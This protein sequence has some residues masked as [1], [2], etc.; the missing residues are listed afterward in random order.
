MDDRITYNRAKTWQIALFTLNNTATNTALF[1]MGYYAYFSQNILGLAAVM[2]GGIA[3]AMRVFDG[4]TDPAIGFMLDKTNTKFGR[5]RP[6]MLA[7][8]LIMCVCIAGI[9]HA[10]TGM[11]TAG[12]YIYTTVL[13]V[14][15][16]IGYTCQTAVTK[17]AQAVITN[18]PKQRPLF[19][20]FDA[21]FTRVSGAMI[22]VLITTILAEKYAIGDYAGAGMLNP[23]MWRVASV[24]LCTAILAMTIL[25]MAGISAKDKPEYYVK[26]GAAKVQLKDY[27]DIIVHNR[28]IQMLIIAAATDKLGSLLQNGLLVYLFA[29]L[30]LNSKMQGIYTI[31]CLVPVMAAA[32]IG[33]GVAR[34]VGLKK[35]FVAGT[36]GSLIMLLILFVYKPDP[37][38]PWIWIVLYIIQN[39]I[40]VFANGSVIPMLADCTDYETYRSGKFVPGMIGTMF[41]FIDKLLSSLSSLIVGIALT[42]AGVGNTTIVPNQPVGGR[43]NTVILL[44]F[45]G[46]PILGYI[47]SL[48][49]M[50]FYELDAAKM[51]K[52]QAGL[53]R[54]KI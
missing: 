42:V 25:A 30:L 27:V 20:G 10:P 2:V 37:N 16:I 13:Y 8:S 35:N 38:V 19:S 47:A 53:E 3:T 28:P 29:N 34:K 51:E 46:I 33:V 40:V 36:T 6:F 52:I 44:C 5:F 15:Y 14:L 49:S 23:E 41:S 9:F 24:I 48:I 4:I 31:V 26:T 1:L 39:C 11:S 50:K 32:F 18:D 43:F 22:S 17:A 54:R 7:G 21:L 45:C 12:A